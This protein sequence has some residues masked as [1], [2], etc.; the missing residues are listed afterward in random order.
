MFWQHQQLFTAE[1]ATA[2]SSF[3]FEARR[4]FFQKGVCVC[5]STQAMFTAEQVAA[6]LFVEKSHAV[7]KKEHCCQYLVLFQYL[8]HSRQYYA[9]C[10]YLSIL[11]LVPNRFV[12]TKESFSCLLA[13]DTT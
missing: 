6:D 3:L 9:T 4:V 2:N 5:W 12:P 10:E 1:Q 8:T 13:R 7:L 11:L